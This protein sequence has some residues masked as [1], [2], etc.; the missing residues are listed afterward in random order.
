M[1]DLNKKILFVIIVIL[2][3]GYS[4]FRI[5]SIGE[6]TDEN[7]NAEEKVKI[8]KL[9]EDFGSKIKN[10]ALLSPREDLINS[11]EENYSQF[12]SDE[13]ME[14]W[15]NDPR[16][17]V[18]R[19]TSS[20]WPDRIEVIDYEKISDDEYNVIGRII[21]ITSTEVENGKIAAVRPVKVS[22]KKI[23]DNWII[24]NVEVGRY[25]EFKE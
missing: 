6:R 17:A 3:F 15:K 23:G 25:E 12:I 11:I 5:A 19:A 14:K 16:K 1:S 24:N 8:E 20:P 10:V 22:V 7:D 13:L 21:E 2:I 9:I 4:F 18:G